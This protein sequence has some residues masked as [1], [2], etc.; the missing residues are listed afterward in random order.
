MDCRRH[1]HAFLTRS[2][3][4][5]NDKRN[6]G[7][8]GGTETSRF[9]FAGFVTYDTLN[10][11]FFFLLYDV[12]NFGFRLRLRSAWMRARECLEAL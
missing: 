12:T 3:F 4:L 8:H 1:P 11:L 7:S 5:S 10:I 2:R 9:G 6:V